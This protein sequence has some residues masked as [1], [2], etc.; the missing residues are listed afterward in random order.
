[1]KLR[2]CRTCGRVYID[3]GHPDCPDCRKAEDTDYKKVRDHLRSHPNS[4]VDDIQR[5]TGV[6]PG[7]ILEFLRKG[8]LMA[9]HGTDELKCSVCGRPV[10]RGSLCSACLGRLK[11]LEKGAG[12]RAASSGERSG[13][14]HTDRWLSERRNRA[15]LDVRRRK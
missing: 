15:Q 3:V 4:S 6:G 9:S 12:P 7:R 5:A 14:M 1:L 11:G 13:R 10:A 8:R 2:N